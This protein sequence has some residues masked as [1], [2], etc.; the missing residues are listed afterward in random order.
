MRTLLQIQQDLYNEEEAD[1][2]DKRAI[3][4]LREELRVTKLIQRNKELR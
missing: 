4:C 2:L 1:F 3:A